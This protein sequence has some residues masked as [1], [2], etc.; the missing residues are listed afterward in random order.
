MGLAFVEGVDYTCHS[1]QQASYPATEALSLIFAPEWLDGPINGIDLSSTT[2]SGNSLDAADLV[3]PEFGWPDQNP[4]WVQP[5]RDGS[6]A[7][8]APARNA[9]YF[10]SAGTDPS[11]GMNTYRK[12][13][14]WPI[15]V[16]MPLS[17]NSQSLWWILVNQERLSCTT[18]Q[19]VMGTGYLGQPQ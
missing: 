2:G 13:E 18:C 12:K 5:I 6:L 7:A 4:S 10:L 14:L 1:M 16:R 15:D 11:I 19:L 3:D 9:Y 17:P 8:E